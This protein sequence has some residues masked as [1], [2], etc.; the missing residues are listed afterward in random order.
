[1]SD[2]TRHEQAR[3]YAIATLRLL[4]PDDYRQASDRYAAA[5][6]ILCGDPEWRRG[7]HG[8][9]DWEHDGEDD[10]TYYVVFDY[11]S[12]EARDAAIEAAEKYTDWH[13]DVNEF[14]WP[15]PWDVCRECGCT[16]TGDEP[17]VCPD[18][19]GDDA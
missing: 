13:F 4:H 16:L 7:E 2:T 11:P 15:S 9:Y 1:M 18:C 8:T 19:E 17:G 10:T 3:Y 14:G 6:A 12:A 5:Y